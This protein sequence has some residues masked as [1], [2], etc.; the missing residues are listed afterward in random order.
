[1][2]RMPNPEQRD[3]AGPP[4][5]PPAPRTRFR[6]ELLAA[7]SAVLLA[8]AVLEHAGDVGC[9]WTDVMMRLGVR[10]F[11]QERYTNLGVLATGLVALLVALKV[12]ANRR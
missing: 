9:T 6:R 10:S 5:P 1:M 7:P 11:N 12:L 4:Q 8:L 2:P 3:P